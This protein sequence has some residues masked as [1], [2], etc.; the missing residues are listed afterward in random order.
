MSERELTSNLL[1]RHPVW[2]WDDS[3]EGHLPVMTYDPLPA[4]L[5][6]LFI[7]AKFEAA[8]GEGLRGY[9]VGDVLVGDVSFYAVGLF[10]GGEDFPLN[11]GLTEFLA[12]SVSRIR[13]LLGR[14]ALQLFPL[15]YVDDV[16]FVH[17]PPLRG[18]LFSNLTH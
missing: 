10:V 9:L 5:G 15:K 17:S 14:P 8:S 18:V 3:M 12:Q 4:D 1:A 7:R 6:T 16:G 13:Q 2:Q 11:V